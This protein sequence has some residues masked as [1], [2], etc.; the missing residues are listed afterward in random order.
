[1]SPPSEVA[2]FDTGIASWTGSEWI[3]TG[4]DVSLL[5]SEF[6]VPENVVK[7]RLYHTGQGY[8]D[9]HLN[10]KRITDNYFGTGW[11]T[12]SKRML[13]DTIDITNMLAKGNNAIGA[14]ISMGWADWSVFP[15]KTGGPVFG[16][17][18]LK[19][20]LRI[21]LESGKIMTFSTNSNWTG[22]QAPIVY[23]SVYNGE[24]YDARLQQ[25]GWDSTN[26]V[27]PSFAQ[28]KP[29]SVT[30][31]PGG[32]VT[33]MMHPGVKEI[34][35]FGSK[36]VTI[37]QPKNG[38]YVV[39]FPRNFS[40]VCRIR[41]KGPTGTTITLRHAEILVH[42]PYSGEPGMIYTENLRSALATDKF[43]LRG[44]GQIEEYSPRHT[45]HGFQYVEVTGYPGELT[46]DN[47]E[48][49]H[50]AS[51]LPLRSSLTFSSTVLTSLHE[52]II[53]GQRSNLMSVP[54]DCDQRDERLGWMGD[55]NLSAESF[56]LNF[57]MANFFA[58]FL[59]LIVDEQGDDGSI[60]DVVPTVRYGNRP[61]DTSWST[62]FTTITWALY[63]FYGEL[64]PAVENGKA[65]DAFKGFLDHNL[66]TSGITGIVAACTTASPS[67]KAC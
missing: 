31:G 41:A 48:A 35:T 51:A 47:I 32:Q 5:R 2:V 45:Y 21:F 7:A 54:T 34:L 16:P 40:G 6:T 57:D 14:I 63:R 55:A 53:W 26:F 9:L 67:S 11:T 61:G 13:Y 10:G 3:T 18:Q 23:A 19:C 59:R 56:C 25:D 66:E 1:M 39:K 4:L 27:P 46:P 65:L 12:I 29:V 20:L 62:A 52:R 28:W 38:T 22:D 36:D 42:P 33:A 24:T 43:I 49:I 60:P 44:D 64:G 17:P 8:Y 30:S 37:T 15:S 58:N 50:I